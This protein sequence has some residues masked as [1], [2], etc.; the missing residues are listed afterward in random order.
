MPEIFEAY[1]DERRRQW[2][3]LMPSGGSFGAVNQQV[4]MVVALMM[5]E[6][7]SM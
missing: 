6:L 2:R 3:V 7:R 1:F 5:T 4:A